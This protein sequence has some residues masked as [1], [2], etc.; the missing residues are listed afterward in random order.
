MVETWP[1]FTCKLT[2]PGSRGDV[3]RRCCVVVRHVN[4][5][6]GGRTT[7]FGSQCSFPLIICSRATFQC[8]GFMSHSDEFGAKFIKS[9]SKKPQHW[10]VAARADNER[11]RTLTAKMRPSFA[12]FSVY[13]P[14]DHAT[15]SSNV[16]PGPRGCKFACKRKSF[17]DHG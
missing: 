4:R 13:M 17:F 14:S 6:N 11:K 9:D 1:A 2:T 15:T 8:C 3:T 12:I 16:T 5:E 10:N 7:H